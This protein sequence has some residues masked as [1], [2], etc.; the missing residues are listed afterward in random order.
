VP[1]RAALVPLGYADGYRRG[2]SDRGWMGIA[3]RKAPVIGRISMD[4]TV[5]RLPDGVTTTV[6]DEVVVMGGI[7]GE[8]APTVDE[9]A[10]LCG[11]ISYEIFTGIA[12]RVPRHVL[13]F[14]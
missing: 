11:T 3:G 14:D 2:L 6:G 1:E 8:A 13:R 4:Q 7:L 12:A 5:V 10:E 9:V